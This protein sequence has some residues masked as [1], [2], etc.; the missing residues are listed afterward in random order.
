VDDNQGNSQIIHQ[1]GGLIQD[2]TNLIVQQAVGQLHPDSILCKKNNK[3][4]GISE[5]TFNELPQT[6]Q[7]NIP[8]IEELENEPKKRN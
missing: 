5:F 4:L 3:R 8:T 7:D 1:A 2:D 6:I